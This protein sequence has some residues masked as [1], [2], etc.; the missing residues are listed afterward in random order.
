MSSVVSEHFAK[1]E[2]EEKVWENIFTYYNQV[3]N[4]SELVF[5]WTAD[6]ITDVTP[7]DPFE[8]DQTVKLTTA[9]TQRDIV[10]NMGYTKTLVNGEECKTFDY[11]I[12]FLN[13]FVAGTAKEVVVKDGIDENTGETKPQVLVKDNS[14][15][16]IYS[17]DSKTKGLALSTIATGTYKLTSDIVSVTYAFD[18]TTAAWK[19]L[20]GNKSDDSILEVSNDEKDAGKVTWKNQGALLQKDYALTVVATVTFKDLSVVKCNIPVRIA[21]K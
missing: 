18:K 12:V 21:K 8:A 10:K 3:D 20:D 7:T 11:N 9:M 16:T 15:E 2:N 1:R 19:E 6:E 4:V 5:A 17:Y 13:P 14:A